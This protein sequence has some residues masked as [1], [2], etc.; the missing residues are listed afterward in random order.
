MV[1]DVMKE[2]EIETPLIV[3]LHN[4]LSVRYVLR[5]ILNNE[6]MRH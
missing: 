3:K 5:I 2:I 6:Q 1:S 4:T